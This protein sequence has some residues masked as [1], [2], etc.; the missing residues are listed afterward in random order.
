MQAKVT[1][2]RLHGDFLAESQGQNQFPRTL[3]LFQL[4]EKSA[5]SWKTNS[6]EEDPKATK[7][8]G[9]RFPI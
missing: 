8:V 2:P 1:F 9:V 5:L 6:V 4:L 7:E 3:G